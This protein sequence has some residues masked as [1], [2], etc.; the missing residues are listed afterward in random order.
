VYWNLVFYE[1]LFKNYVDTMHITSLTVFLSRCL[2]S[3]VR[4]PNS[5]AV[6]DPCMNSRRVQR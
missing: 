5:H 6:S 2:L 3:V 4:V 1:T